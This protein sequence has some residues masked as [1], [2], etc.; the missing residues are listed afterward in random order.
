MRPD[1]TV[2]ALAACLALWLAP[3]G[4]VA[5]QEHPVP[6][7]RAAAGTAP[8][9]PPPPIAPVKD[10]H[11]LIWRKAWPRF[12]VIEFGVTAALL[13]ELAMLEFRAKVRDSPNW[14]GGVLFDDA[15]RDGMRL[16]SREGRET[17]GDIAD[18]ITLGLQIYPLVESIVLPLATDRFN[19]DVATQLTL[20]NVE[21]LGA[22]G[23]ANRFGHKVIGRERPSVAECK[24]DKNYDKFCKGSRY[25]GFPSGHTSGAFLG[26]GMTCAHHM[27]LPLY[28]GG[29]PD[30][31]ACA[32][33]AVLASAD[34]VLRLMGDRHYAT[35]IV[36]GA[37]IGFFAG[38]GI[39]TL[40]HYRFG[41]GVPD[42]AARDRRGT[43]KRGP[44]SLA[45]GA[46]G[47]TLVPSATDDDVSLA[48]RGLF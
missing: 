15:I 33:T 40:L 14:T 23:F 37:A 39:P 41:Y 13:F 29:A 44:G 12:R 21:V 47:V 28:G 31:A 5:A 6:A 22:G 36:A 10:D 35:D 46:P 2:F 9:V 32:A 45:S 18:P 26:V 24:K 11:R 30:V 1:S 38:Y 17:A 48:L 8:A 34:G 16:E 7:E 43:A 42:S 25:A 3:I 20:M 19:V 4:D 27:H